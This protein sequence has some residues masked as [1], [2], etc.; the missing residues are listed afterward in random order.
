MHI[1]WESD[2]ITQP[3]FAMELKLFHKC[4]KSICIVVGKID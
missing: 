2:N 3:I 4:T 1:E